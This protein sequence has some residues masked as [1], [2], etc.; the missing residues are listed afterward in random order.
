MKRLSPKPLPKWAQINDLPWIGKDIAKETAA[1]AHVSIDEWMQDWPIEVADQVDLLHVLSLAEQEKRP[2]HLAAYLAMLIAY[3]DE[4]DLEMMFADQV[5]LSRIETV[6]SLYPEVMCY[7]LCLEEKDPASEGCFPVTPWLRKLTLKLLNQQ[8]F[9]FV[10]CDEDR[11]NELLAI[12]E[13]SVIQTHHFLTPGDIEQLRE[14]VLKQYF[15]M[16]EKI[17]GFIN[18]DWTIKGFIGIVEQRVEMLFVDPAYFGQGVGQRLMTYAIDRYGVN[19]VDVNEQNEQALGFYLH[20]GFQVMG[21]SPLDGQGRPFPILHM[22]L[23]A[24]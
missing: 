16:M 3:L 5:L 24:V 10:P 21:R 15:P 20:M 7:W 4:T 23:G 19:S 6:L 14:P 12:W 9:E 2:D 1:A 18:L 8:A 13:R 22:Q 11:F 17:I